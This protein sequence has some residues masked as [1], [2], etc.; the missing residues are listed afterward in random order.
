MMNRLG[1]MLWI[2]GMWLRAF[3]GTQ[4]RLLIPSERAT[5]K[6]ARHDEEPESE[7]VPPGDDARSPPLTINIPSPRYSACGRAGPS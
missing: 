7:I 4:K 2:T 6:I 5:P 1:T 3:Q